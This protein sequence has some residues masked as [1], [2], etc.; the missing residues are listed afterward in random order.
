[1]NSSAPLSQDAARARRIAAAGWAIILLSAGAALLPV[2]SPAQGAWLIGTMLLLAGLIELLAGMMRH[3][4]R[5]LAVLAGLITVAAGLLFATDQATKFAPTLVIISGWLLLRSLV[6]A[7]ACARES[8]SVKYWTGLAAAADF[9]L[10]VVVTIGYSAA[11]LV[12][13]LFGPTPPMIAHF[14]WVLAI[15]FVATGGML[16]EVARCARR[17]EV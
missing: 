17:E 8:G 14:A 7:I 15:S 10:G 6:L 9:I 2:I 16:L 13:S 1:M 5:M 11:A 4:T 12:I 3:Q